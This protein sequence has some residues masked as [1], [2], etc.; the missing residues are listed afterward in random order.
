MDGLVLCKQ[1]QK[2]TMLLPPLPKVHEPSCFLPAAQPGK[3]LRFLFPSCTAQSPLGQAEQLG[4]VAEHTLK[5]TA[6]SPVNPPPQQHCKTTAC[7][8]GQWRATASSSSPPG[9]QHSL[10]SPSE[11]P[12]LVW[13]PPMAQR[14]QER[15]VPKGFHRCLPISLLCDRA[16]SGCTPCSCTVACRGRTIQHPLRCL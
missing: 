6:D 9:P 2:L 4:G 8:E 11:L 7:N 3:G 12:Q 13:C 1:L 5:C 10:A 14:F 15:G 16:V